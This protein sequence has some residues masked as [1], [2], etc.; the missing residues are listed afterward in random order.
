MHHRANG[1]G[2]AIEFTTTGD[3]DNARWRLTQ[4]EHRRTI[5]LDHVETVGPG[6]CGTQPAEPAKGS[7]Q[8]PLSLLPEISHRHVTLQIKD[9]DV[10]RFG[11]F[12]QSRAVRGLG[13][14][15]QLGVD[16]PTQ[17]DNGPENGKLITNGAQFAGLGQFRA[18]TQTTQ[19][20][21]HQHRQQ[22]HDRDLRPKV[23]SARMPARVDLAPSG[24]SFF[25]HFSGI[26]VCHYT[27]RYPS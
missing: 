16:Q 5:G 11:A 8:V 4:R 6:I 3:R 2:S 25:F 26:L 12:P 7:I 15:D 19:D 20:Q 24:R 23:P 9:L 21:R 17:L 18:Y 22:Q 10:D 1:R 13:R 27:E 14:R